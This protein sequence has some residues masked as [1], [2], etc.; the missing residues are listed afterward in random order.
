[1]GGGSE[2]ARAV[3]RQGS[4]EG[5]GHRTGKAWMA[6]EVFAVVYKDSPG[7]LGTFEYRW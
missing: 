4:R 5:P 2:K 1:M 6:V 3:P 7:D